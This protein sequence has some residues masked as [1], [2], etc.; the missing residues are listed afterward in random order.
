MAA[1]QGKKFLPVLFSGS[2]KKHRTTVPP[3]TERMWRETTNQ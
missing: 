1:L 3:A 2:G